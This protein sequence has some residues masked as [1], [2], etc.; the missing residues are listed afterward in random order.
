MPDMINKLVHGSVEMTAL[1]IVYKDTNNI[2]HVNIARCPCN[3]LVKRERGRGDTKTK[4]KWRKVG[5]EPPYCHIRWMDQIATHSENLIRT[6]RYVEEAGEIGVSDNLEDF[7]GELTLI[8][9]DWEMQGDETRA[10][11]KIPSLNNDGMGRL[12]DPTRTKWGGLEGIR[13]I[14]EMVTFI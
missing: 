10:E 1:S 12:Q 7:R 8:D 13:R 14:S 11:T 6:I 9:E 3:G 4:L 2:R 5:T